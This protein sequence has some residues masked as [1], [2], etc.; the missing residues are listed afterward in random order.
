MSV[1]NDQMT[2]D[3]KL[4]TTQFV[5][6]D[7]S[8]TDPA[9]KVPLFFDSEH[10]AYVVGI[11]SVVTKVGDTNGDPVTVNVGSI[12]DPDLIG[13]VVVTDAATPIV[14]AS[15]PGTLNSATKETVYESHGGVFVPKGTAI[16]PSYTNSGSNI[17][18]R[19]IALK[20]FLADE[21]TFD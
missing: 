20:Y 6:V 3:A 18:E 17:A 5:N 9:N 4:K 10:D 1:T 7:V 16:Y 19:A 8:A 14:G 11:E 21:T 15:V 12:A 13:S 2:V